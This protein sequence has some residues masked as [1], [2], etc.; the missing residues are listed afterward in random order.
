MAS[1]SLGITTNAII[2]GVQSVVCIGANPSQGRAPKPPSRPSMQKT[3]PPSTLF[4]LDRVS[5]FMLILSNPVLLVNSSVEKM[6]C[7]VKE[8]SG[9][10]RRVQSLSCKDIS[11]REAGAV[12]W[13]GPNGTC[14]GSRR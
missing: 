11:L 13:V 14:R 8:R 5:T 3:L 9:R 4:P 7:H 12:L 10:G 2:S 6:H 1:L